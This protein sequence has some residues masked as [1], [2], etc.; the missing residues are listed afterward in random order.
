M[1]AA[2]IVDELIVLLKL[3]TSQYDKAYQRIDVNISLTEKRLKKADDARN[4]R[5]K[6]SISLLNQFSGAM[7]SFALTVGSVLGIGG[8]AA[9]LVQAV[10]A[11]TSFETGLRRAAVSTGLSNREMQAWGSA[12]R[13]L[14]ADAEAGRAA[15]AELAKEQKQFHLTGN[16]P[17]MQAFARLGINVSPDASI[18]DIL[19]N[20]QQ[21][22]RGSSKAQQ[23]QIE[24][25]LS[26]SGV[27]NDLILLIK[28][29]KDVRAEFAR[30]YAESATENR[31]ALDSVT[32]ALEAAK[33]S[34]LNIANA[35]ASALQPQIEQF[36]QWLSNG[37]AQVSAFV[38]KVIAA[39][40]GVQGFTKV[41]DSEAPELARLLRMLGQAVAFMGEMVDVVAFG[42]KKLAA[43]AEALYTWIDEKVGYVLGGPGKVKG[44]VTDFGEGV[45]KGW[46]MLVGEARDAA[47]RPGGGV[48]LTPEAQA[49]IAAGAT[50]APAT[51]GSSA[52]ASPTG[53]ARVAPRGGNATQDEVMRGLIARGF[54][55]DQAAAVAANIKHESNYNPAAYNPGGGGIGA[56][57]L[58][59]LRGDRARAFQARY[60]KLP[61]QATLDEQLDF[62]ASND[63]EERRSRQAA[64]AAGGSAAQLGTAV[65]AKYERH[66]NVAE[67]LRRGQTAAAIAAQYNQ[68]PAVGQQININGPVTVQA[69]DPKELAGG[70]QRVSGATNYNSAVR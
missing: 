62:F 27:S 46:R 52:A 32:N 68:Q 44:A 1:A 54:T 19:A 20:A 69:N 59:Q 11:L 14:G 64:F 65:S 49:R 41:L 63:P 53:A 25:G 10:V 17:T 7:R 6:E 24:A 18:T 45:A 9:G 66:G 4:K 21:I 5:T 51:A 47:A 70:I 61:S 50:G 28:S 55:V 34:A 67:D 31:K 23:G 38:D 33:N 2:N 35:L 12:A 43:A 58:F 39:G 29:E 40:G 15:I 30:S 26:A 13:R 48:T 3:D 37:A 16:A 56:H 36:G 22:Y 42:F 57:G 8:G 60:G